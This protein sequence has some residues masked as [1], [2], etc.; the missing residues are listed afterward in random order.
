MKVECENLSEQLATPKLIRD[1]VRD[2]KRRGEFMILIHD[3]GAFVQVSCDSDQVEGSN[4]GSFVLEYRESK[5]GRLFHCTQSV[6]A[7]EVENIFLDEL[8]GRGSWR[9]R[10]TWEPI[11]GY[12][13][14]SSTGGLHLPGVKKLVWI[15]HLSS[16]LLI[17][18]IL[19]IFGIC[20]VPRQDSA[21]SVPSIG[22]STM[23]WME[24]IAGQNMRRYSGLDKK[25]RVSC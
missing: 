14:T 9:N 12:G 25:L 19:H 3:D 1:L 10:Y 16:C 23:L 17:P 5:N 11:E 20:M 24:S 8:D 21:L 4:G 22:A 7:R 2:D 15:F 6:S 18:H 13:S